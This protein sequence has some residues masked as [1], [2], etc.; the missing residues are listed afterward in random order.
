MVHGARGMAHRVWCREAAGREV[1][2]GCVVAHGDRGEVWRREMHIVISFPAGQGAGWERREQREGGLQGIPVRS[3]SR[4]TREVKVE[5]EALATREGGRQEGIEKERR[6]R[7]DVGSYR[8][9]PMVGVGGSEGWTGL[10]W[11]GRGG[12]LRYGGWWMVLGAGVDLKKRFR[13]WTRH[14]AAV[15]A[16]CAAGAGCLVPTPAGSAGGTLAL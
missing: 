6:Q 7:G 12:R 5:A 10:G 8:A 1:P 9:A 2:T 14:E 16:V 13:T 3:S 15:A 11:T 4:S